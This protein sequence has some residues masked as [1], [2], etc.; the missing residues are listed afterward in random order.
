M[1]HSGYRTLQRTNP[2]K[3]GHKNQ[4]R[5]GSTLSDRLITSSNIFNRTLRYFAATVVSI[6]LNSDS[7]HLEGVDLRELRGAVWS[8][9]DL[10]QIAEIG[11]MVCSQELVRRLRLELLCITCTGSPVKQLF[12]RDDERVFISSRPVGLASGKFCTARTP[13]DK[14]LA[15]EV[16]HVCH[17][18][19]CIST[20]G[21]YTVSSTNSPTKHKFQ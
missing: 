5:S 21:R 10:A 4:S 1:R 8:C 13:P 6:R 20:S 18:S 16:K 2:A 11:F 15:G 12:Q 17:N 14:A 3:L 7:L 19:I 9:R